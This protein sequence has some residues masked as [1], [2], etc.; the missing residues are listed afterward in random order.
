M[1]SRRSHHSKTIQTQRLE[2]LK[3]NITKGNKPKPEALKPKAFKRDPK[4]LERFICS[5]ENM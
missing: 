4:D 5:L 2:L 1:T 3:R